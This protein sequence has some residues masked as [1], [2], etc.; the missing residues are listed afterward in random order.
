MET[1]FGLVYTFTHIIHLYIYK[2]IHLKYIHLS[3]YPSIYLFNYLSIYL[4]GEVNRQSSAGTLPRYTADTNR[5]SATS[6][7]YAE[8]SRFGGSSSG[9]RDGLEGGARFREGVSGAR[10]VEGGTAQCYGEGG[11]AAQGATG[12]YSEGTKYSPRG[13][14]VPHSYRHGPNHMFL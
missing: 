11:M 14:T 8:S 7:R 12:R 6:P 10:Y 1:C 2:L 4:G 3:I 13:S 9:S 5:Y